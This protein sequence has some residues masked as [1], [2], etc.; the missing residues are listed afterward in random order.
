VAVLAV[1]AVLTV[2]GTLLLLAGAGEALAPPVPPGGST[3]AIDAQMTLEEAAWREE[4]LG[5]GAG[6]IGLHE[7]LLGQPRL[8]DRVRVES[9]H[10]LGV[11]HSMRGNFTP[12]V[13][14]FLRLVREFPE[15][16][17]F[18]RK[19]SHNL[20]LL[21]P[22]ASPRDRSWFQ[23]ERLFLGELALLLDPLL[24]PS[25]VAQEGAVRELVGEM[26]DALGALRRQVVGGD[27]E[28]VE[29]AIPALEAL[30]AP[31]V[32]GGPGVS[33]PSVAVD[34]PA[35]P[36]PV[37][38]AWARSAARAWLVDRTALFAPD[39][40]N[41]RVVEC[42]DRLARALAA[43]DPAGVRH[44]ADRAA[45]WAGPINRDGRPSLTADYLGMVRQAAEAVSARMSE[46]RLAEARAVWLQAVR[47]LRR[48]FGA[49]TLHVPGLSDFPPELT[50][51]LVAVLGCVDESLRALESPEDS[52]DPVPPLAEA[53]DRVRAI[54]ARLGA[55]TGPVAPD[56][57]RPVRARLRRWLDDWAV[58]VD[59]LRAGDL[60][61]ARQLLK[62]YGL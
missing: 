62:P 14:L 55:A 33:G 22:E 59:T 18:A 54:D 45:R 60:V 24:D 35:G 3:S 12:A 32:P 56:P 34:G 37:R 8:P 61:R 25:G 21:S 51:E 1:L 9:M 31:D 19:A 15:A 47:T 28:A 53:I 10:R 11:C 13:A 41:A 48:S 44:E 58:V 50:P 52:G 43:G 2:L 40:A 26:L 38:A 4:I 36:V 27:L 30:L 23:D 39:D 46:G 7:R 6:A 5:D 42:R 16:E 20:L 29:R 17:P 49:F 57:D